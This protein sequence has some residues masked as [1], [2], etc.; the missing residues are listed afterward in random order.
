M[1]TGK[2]RIMREFAIDEISAVTK[3]AQKGARMIIMKRADAGGDLVAKGDYVLTSVEDGHQHLIC[4]DDAAEL[5]GGG[6]TEGANCGDGADYHTHPFAIDDMGN[7]LIGEAMAHGHELSTLSQNVEDLEAAGIIGDNIEE[8]NEAGG[9]QGEGGTETEKARMLADNTGAEADKAC[10]TAKRAFSAKQRRAA[11][12]SGAALPDGSYPIKNTADLKNAVSAWGRAPE[13]KRAAV[14]RHIASRAKSLG[15]TDSLPTSGPLAEALGRAK[16]SAAST[17]NQEDENMAKIE[18]DEA[19]FAE[20]TALATM[21]DAQRA[22]LG[23]LAKGADRDAFVKADYS[24]RDAIIAKA[25]AGSADPVVYASKA[26]VEIRKSDGGAALALAK[27]LD[28]M[29]DTNDRLAKALEATTEA[30]T[31]A[32]VERI[33]KGLE[34][35]GKPIEEKREMVK[36]ILGLPETARKTALDA[37][38]AGAAPFATMMKHAGVANVPGMQGTAVEQID[39]LARE[40]ISKTGTAE[41][42][43]QAYVAVLQTPEGVRLYSETLN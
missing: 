6:N 35:I 32:E 16:K 19:K 38:K 17:Q 18:I 40:R 3:P 20:L 2:K 7:V 30:A 29:V 33:V 10:L 23:K 42:Y 36:G 22:H 25:H 26:G 21:S 24:G 39:K 31:A 15:A 11:A 34:H 13:G 1:T 43:E 41:T 9:E 5:R 28:A 14:A 27:Q 8:E 4:L 12:S 37:L